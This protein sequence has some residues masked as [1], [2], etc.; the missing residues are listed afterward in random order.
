MD[1]TQQNIPDGEH[2]V[3]QQNIFY[4][5]CKINKH[6]LRKFWYSNLIYK[7]VWK[8]VISFI[9]LCSCWIIDNLMFHLLNIYTL[10][11]VGN[12]P[13]ID[14]QIYILSF[15]DWMSM[16]AVQNRYNDTRYY[17]LFREFKLEYNSLFNDTALLSQILYNK[18]LL[19]K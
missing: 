9:S 17:A 13:Y 18:K 8:F 7:C 3:W 16:L 12:Q 11:I 19:H 5:T 10:I 6:A 2:N 4:K 14:N 15:R 1:Q